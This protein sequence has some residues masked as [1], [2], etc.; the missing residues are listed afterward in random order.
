MLNQTKDELIEVCTTLMALSSI[1]VGLRLYSR[2]RQHVALMVDDALTVLQISWDVLSTTSLACI[3]LSALF[4]YRIIFYV[5][6]HQWFDIANTVTIIVVV[7]WLVVF[8]FLTGFQCGTHFSALWDGSYLQYCTVSFP[9]LYGLAVSDFLLDVWILA[10]PIPRIMQ[11]HTSA[12]KKL[13][14][15]V[16]FLL[17]FIGLG[18]SIARMVEYIKIE[19]GGSHYFI[20]HDEEEAVTSAF[21]FTMLETGIS[22]VAVNLPSL[23]LLF[24]SV[25]PK[26]VI[27]TIRSVL[28]LESLRSRGSGRRGQSTGRDGGD[29]FGAAAVTG[30]YGMVASTRPSESSAKLHPG[31]PAGLPNP[32][33]ESQWANPSEVRGA[34]SAKPESLEL[35]VYR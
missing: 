15:V 20:H 18:A 13:G 30:K 35:G 33:L 14:I 28:S 11:L 17:V 26:K 32:D 25:T 2:K 12:S 31:V 23:W 9:F 10:L 7:V 1:A 5:G 34:A 4:F 19:N 3:K 22:L 8:Q 6:L 27:R 24:T 16:V 21:L 29:K